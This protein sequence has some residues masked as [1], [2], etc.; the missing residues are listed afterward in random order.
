[1]HQAFKE[2][3]VLQAQVELLQTSYQDSLA[4]SP[5]HTSERLSMQ[6]EFK[7]FSV[8]RVSQTKG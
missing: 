7:P 4:A 1:M 5:L 6:A 2:L 8:F 3:I